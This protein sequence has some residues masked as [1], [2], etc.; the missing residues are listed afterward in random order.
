VLP[1]LGLAHRLDGAR[2][3]VSAARDGSS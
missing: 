2:V 1:T 3:I